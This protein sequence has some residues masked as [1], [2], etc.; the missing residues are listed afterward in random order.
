[1]YLIALVGLAEASGPRL[2]AL[3]RKQASREAQG[4]RITGQQGDVE[5]VD[6]G[7]ACSWIDGCNITSG[8]CDDWG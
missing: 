8:R 4:G 3:L 1:M 2:D 5:E 7:R 6:R